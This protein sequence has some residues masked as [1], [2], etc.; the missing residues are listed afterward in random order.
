MES[1]EQVQRTIRMNAIFGNI[2][3]IDPRDAR[4]LL[5][6]L[7]AQTEST[8]AMLGEASSV[9]NQP[10]R[11]RALSKDYGPLE[12]CHALFE[13]VPLL[14]RSSYQACQEMASILRTSTWH[15]AHN[16][17][18]PYFCPHCVHTFTLLI[19]HPAL[20]PLQREELTGL[21]YTLINAT[22]ETVKGALQ[23]MEQVRRQAAVLPLGPSGPPVSARVLGTERDRHTSKEFA[24]VMQVT[25]SNGFV[26][27]CR[28]TH[29][30][31]F[32][33]QCTML[34]TYPEAAKKDERILPKLTGKRV[35]STKSKVEIANS[36][37]E[38]IETYLQQLFKM[39]AELSQCPELRAFFASCPQCAGTLSTCSPNCTLLNRK[40]A[41]SASLA[42]VETA[43]SFGTRPSASTAIGTP[44]PQA[45]MVAPT[46]PT[47]IRVT[48]QPGSGPGSPTLQPG[49]PIRPQSPVPMG[50]APSGPFNPHMGMAPGFMFPQ[51]FVYPQLQPSMAPA[52]NGMV[53][54]FPPNYGAAPGYAPARGPPLANR[55]HLAQSQSRSEPGRRSASPSPGVTHAAARPLSSSLAQT[56][57]AGDAVTP[58]HS[59]GSTDTGVSVMSASNT[60]SVPTSPLSA[61]KQ[62]SSVQSPVKT[63]DTKSVERRAVADKEE[64]PQSRGRSRKTSS[65]QGA[66]KRSSSIDSSLSVESSASVV[67]ASNATKCF[68]C[69]Q[70]DHDTSQCKA[71]VTEA[72]LR[73]TL[74]DLKCHPE[75]LDGFTLP[76]LRQCVQQYAWLKQLRLHKYGS[77]L[78]GRSMETLQSLDEAGL[79]ELGLTSGAAKKLH[80]HLK[81]YGAV[82][83]ISATSS[84]TSEV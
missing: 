51:P 73:Q 26:Q 48:S 16:T 20:P 18:V 66:H 81:H 79:R 39:P 57:A 1:D 82:A 35:F 80:G 36:R 25:W 46:T 8:A 27:D 75:G 32:D 67:S 54:A 55:H 28:R 71:S 45:T 69:A 30:Q 68:L 22:Q 76:E 21:L 77:L 74:S 12:A 37:L 53:S 2:N 62:Q 43:A 13:L 56:L 49:A 64:G 52:P 15:P 41:S 61:R 14:H 42:G 31:F 11:I 24:F 60:P 38:S 7:E 50:F 17:T 84:V 72:D 65:N 40:G 58:S 34:D 19:N 9:A 4:Y 70:Q 59:N 10:D 3:G 5:T 44:T 33:F 47:H 6:L 83:R 29:E 23:Q 63:Q 78:A